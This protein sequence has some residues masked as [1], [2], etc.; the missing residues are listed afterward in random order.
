METLCVADLSLLLQFG[1]PSA[2]GLGKTSLL[3]Y[4]FND[5]RRKFLF[6]DKTDRIWRDSCVDVVFS[7]QF[8]VFDVHGQASD[9]KL[10][11][12]IQ[13]YAFAQII[14]I[15]SDDLSGEF[16]QT[17]TINFVSDIQTIIVIFDPKYDDNDLIASQELIKLFE[18]KFQKW[19]NVLWT[20]APVLSLNQN[21]VSRKMKQR[22]KR[23]RETFSHLLEQVN[24]NTKPLSFRSCLQIQS[25]FYAG[26]IIET[27]LK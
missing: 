20:T 3:G 24:E 21:L 23:L 25:S 14:Y 6:T 5:K 19:S 4:I 17:E 15:T 2:C 26:K 22:N 27:N 7:S 9:V 11:Q 16:F 10:I 12:S 1:S 18:N 8:V 13:P